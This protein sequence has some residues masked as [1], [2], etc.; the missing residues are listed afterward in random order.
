MNKFDCKRLAARLLQLQNF[1]EFHVKHMY[2]VYVNY[3]KTFNQRGQCGYK[4]ATGYCGKHRLSHLTTSNWTATAQQITLEFKAGM[5]TSLCTRTI[6][7]TMAKG[8]Y[9]SRWPHHITLHLMLTAKCQQIRLQCAKF[10]CD[11]TMDDWKHAV[12]SEES[13]FLLHYADGRVH[14]WGYT[15]WSNWTCLA[16]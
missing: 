12:W 6:H 11:W 7:Y 4:W 2:Q 5:S 9:G 1:W 13:W 16:M 10:D 15:T 3:G 14:V 8:G